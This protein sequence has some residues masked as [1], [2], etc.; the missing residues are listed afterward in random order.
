MK[1]SVL[2]FIGLLGIITACSNTKRAEQAEQAEQ[3]LDDS[4]R[5]ADSISRVEAMEAAEAA[6]LDSIRQDSIN[7][8]KVLD[9]NFPTVKMLTSVDMDYFGLGMKDAN[10]L[11]NIFT[12]R[13]Y[14]KEGTNSYIFDEGGAHQVIIKIIPEKIENLE[15][16]Y[17][18]EEQEPYYI[19]TNVVLTFSDEKDA[20]KFVNTAPRKL[21]Q[22]KRNKNVVT[23]ED[24]SG[25]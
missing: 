16:E 22:I 2:I 23:V 5:A 20:I 25:D 8:A 24:R 4:I 12:A 17:S 1:K 13:G 21:E 19:L 10:Q 11:R 18:P 3:V 6:R 14:K 9:K 7:K 15:Y